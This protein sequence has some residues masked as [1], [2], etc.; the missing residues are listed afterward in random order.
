[1]STLIQPPSISISNVTTNSVDL[2]INNFGRNSV[3]LANIAYIYV[4]DNSNVFFF[5]INRAVMR[6][7]TINRITGLLPNKTY[8]FGV[9]NN[10][11]QISNIIS[12]TTQGVVVTP[13]PSS[14]RRPS[15]TVGVTP[16]VTP[17]RPSTTVGVTPTNTPTR[18]STTIGVTPTVTPTRPSPT[19]TIV[20]PS[21]SSWFTS[22]STFD[23]RDGSFFTIGYS[24]NNINNISICRYDDFRVLPSNVVKFDTN[25]YVNTQNTNP[26][27]R[28]I[29]TVNVKTNYPSDVTLFW[30][31][32][33][34]ATNTEE[35]I[36]IS[37]PVK[38]N[39]PLTSINNG[40]AKNN[41]TL[42]IPQIVYPIL[43][44]PQPSPSP[45]PTPTTTRTPVPTLSGISVTPTNTPTTTR[46]PVPTLSGISVSPTPTPTRS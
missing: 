23:L 43:P 39:A 22:L 5:P 41:I 36:L 24:N 35:S 12:A 44:T 6:G 45:T 21:I 33:F 14:T 15:T 29:S 28:P 20:I 26:S 2:N 1:M 37:L 27:F 32:G 11:N 10:L 18:P 25:I 8:F 30:I 7:Q 3:L 40:V 19:P 13:T 34:G 46:T 16:T 9:R 17:T 38:Y 31:G 4:A 42:D